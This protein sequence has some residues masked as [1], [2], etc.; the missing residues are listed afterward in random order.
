M[1]PGGGGGLRSRKLLY[2]L[3]RFLSPSAPVL[4]QDRVYCTDQPPNVRL[5]YCRILARGDSLANNHP[6]GR[7]YPGFFLASWD[8]GFGMALRRDAKSLSSLVRLVEGLRGSRLHLVFPQRGDAEASKDKV[9][10]R[11]MSWVQ[12]GPIPKETTIYP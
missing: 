8:L 11:V 6:R 4:L 12:D 5:V 3:A 10:V 7:Q 9:V 2:L 1:L